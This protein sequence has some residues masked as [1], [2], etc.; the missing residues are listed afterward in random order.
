[1]TC[2]ND[3]IG[4]NYLQ[5]QKFS[6]IPKYYYIFV[7]TV[8]DEGARVLSATDGLR[9]HLIGCFASEE[10]SPYVYSIVKIPKNK[11]TQNLFLSAMNRLYNS[12][13]LAD[14]LTYCEVCKTFHNILQTPDRFPEINDI[15]E[16]NE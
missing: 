10:Q 2:N 8:E 3:K 16:G 15:L 7:D 11:K 6:L 13:C 9:Y 1:M 5:V 4:R 12:M 14:G